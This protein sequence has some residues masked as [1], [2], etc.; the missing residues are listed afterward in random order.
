MRVKLQPTLENLA[1]VF[2]FLFLLAALYFVCAYADSATMKPQ[3]EVAPM[4]SCSY[5]AKACSSDKKKCPVFGE[6]CDCGCIAG[7]ECGC[8]VPEIIGGFLLPTEKDCERLYHEAG[9]Q[10][11]A[12]RPYLDLYGIQREWDGSYHWAGGGWQ[13]QE[14]FRR[15][16]L[17][18]DRVEKLKAVY[19]AA[20]WCVWPRATPAQQLEWRLELESRL[21]ALAKD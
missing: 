12:F 9:K 5:C 11:D 14:C 19:W 2:L 1:L 8:L 17:A 4:P 18:E 3:I 6:K 10:L 21:K 15:F 20:W 13:A 7:G 16:R